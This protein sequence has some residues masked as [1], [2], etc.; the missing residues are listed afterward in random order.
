MNA[1]RLSVRN[2]SKTYPKGDGSVLADITFDVANGEVIAVVGRNGCGKSTLLQIIAGLLEPSSGSTEL[3]E[4]ESDDIAVGMVFQDYDKS[5]LP[6][7][8]CLD[9]IT[10]PLEAHKHMRA[11]ERR[12]RARAF[13]SDLGIDLPLKN[14]PYEMSGGQKQLT[15][16]VRAL[17]RRP[18]LLLLDEP[19]A[20]LDYFN[21]HEVRKSLQS[22]LA[23]MNLTCVFVS[24]ELDDAV[25]MSDRVIVLAGVPT[26]TRR[27]V[28]LESPRPRTDPDSVKR[29][30]EEIL[31]AL[32]VA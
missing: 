27:I 9:N 26:T 31:E 25:L 22:I 11:L 5:L 8:S 23:A 17:I 7:R 12:E 2:V 19:F 32:E 28:I 21:R 10:L 30:R 3:R 1:V 20:A 4:T 14:Y 24:H 13:I 18:A 6:W 15:C 16:V 29:P